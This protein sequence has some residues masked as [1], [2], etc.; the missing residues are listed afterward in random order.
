MTKAEVRAL[1]AEKGLSTADRLDS[2]DFYSGD[3]NELIGEADREGDI[4]D[5]SGKVLG[6]HSGFWRYTVGQ[7]KGIGVYGPEPHYVIRL[8]SGRNQVVVGGRQEAFK[9]EFKVEDLKW[10]ASGPMDGAI[11]CRVKIR[12]TGEPLGPVVFE[13]GVCRADGD[14]LFGVA[15]GQSAVFYDEADRIVC[16]GVIA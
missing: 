10:M 15:P 3:K 12:S 9:T 5:I 4:V 14:G 11:Q 1:A 7:R 13:N 6:R 2:Q 8:D 16:G